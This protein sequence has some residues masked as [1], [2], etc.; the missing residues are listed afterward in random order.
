MFII[1]LL[2]GKYDHSAISLPASKAN[3]VAAPLK[4]KVKRAELG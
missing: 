1:Q 4:D 2:D 3:E